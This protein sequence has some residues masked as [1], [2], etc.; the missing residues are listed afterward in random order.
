MAL[1]I[2]A[3]E[4]S[5]GRAITSRIP[6]LIASAISVAEP[7]MPRRRSSVRL[8][9]IP[10]GDVAALISRAV[11]FHDLGIVTEAQLLVEINR[12][13]ALSVGQQVQRLRMHR[14]CPIDGRR[15]EELARLK[16]A[17]AGANAH[18]R[19]VGA[20]HHPEARYG[21]APRQPTSSHTHSPRYRR[22]SADR[23]TPTKSTE[24][25]RVPPRSGWGSRF[26][27]LA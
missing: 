24:G 8:A 3:R 23:L 6:F 18:L 20:Y 1:S 15:Q 26:D 9:P 5:S 4:S 13:L 25:H 22:D 7:G 16:A 17:R 11:L 2:T 27:S 21:G 14:R 12:R 19:A 10:H